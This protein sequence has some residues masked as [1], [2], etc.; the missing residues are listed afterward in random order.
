MT[1]TTKGTCKIVR[2][3]TKPI[4]DIGPNRARI[5]LGADLPYGFTFTGGFQI[6]NFRTDFGAVFFKKSLLPT[7]LNIAELK[8]SMI[9]KEQSK[10][11]KS[12]DIQCLFNKKR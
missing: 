7:T 8:S 3:L 9:A 6:F 10:R 5:K 1:S 11:G 2:A 12:Y 4:K